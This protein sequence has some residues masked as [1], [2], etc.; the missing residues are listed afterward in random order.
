MKRDAVQ[1]HT[2][3]ILVLLDVDTIRVIG[4]DFVQ[5]NDVHDHQHQQHD[6]YGNDVQREKAVQSRIRNHE[7]AANPER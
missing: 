2:I 1:R 7:I 3:G 6:R 5:R 4:A